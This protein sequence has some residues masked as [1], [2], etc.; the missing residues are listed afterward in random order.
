MASEIGGT[1]IA[2]YRKAMDVLHRACLFVA[3]TCLV[4]ITLIIP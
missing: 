3:G 4:V 2:Q 1:M